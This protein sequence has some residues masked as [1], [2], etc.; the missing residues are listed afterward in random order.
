MTTETLTMDKEQET[1]RS[2]VRVSRV[3]PSLS[4]GRSSGGWRLWL[5]PVALVATAG[6]LF[7]FNGRHDSDLE[8]GEAARRTVA[9][10]VEQLLSYD[11]RGIE[12]D[13]ERERAWLT[14]SF[15]DDYASLVTEEI[16]PAAAKV[17][18][19]TEATVTA[20]GVTSADH[21]EVVV[22]VFVNVTTRSSELD[23]PRVSGSRLSVTAKY[24]DGEWRISA[25][26]PV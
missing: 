4:I 3:V 9:T 22:L 16:A 12:A 20:S 6:L 13:L 26:E 21:D 1:G 8:G 14:G 5:V 10:H 25:L 19:V 15:A 17:K 24:V 18:V 2:A 7:A 11:Y 23:Q